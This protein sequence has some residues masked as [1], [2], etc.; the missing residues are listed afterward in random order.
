MSVKLGIIAPLANAKVD[1][2]NTSL[3]KFIF[4]SFAQRNF[5]PGSFEE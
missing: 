2:L 3:Q 1:A 5:P 4:E